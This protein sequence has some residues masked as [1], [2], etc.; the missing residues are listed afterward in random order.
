MRHSG[1]NCEIEKKDKNIIETQAEQ[2]VRGWMAIHTGYYLST[3]CKES[4]EMLSDN[5]RCAPPAVSL[6]SAK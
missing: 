6:H 4:T 2:I 5:K 3:T 1:T